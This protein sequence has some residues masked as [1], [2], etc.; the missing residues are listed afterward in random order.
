MSDE[1]IRVLVVDDH[2]VVRQGFTM[3]L[4]AF[5]EFQLVGEAKNGLHAVQLCDEL[6]PDV[7]LMDMVMPEM[8][9]IEATR[10]IREQHKD[11][12]VIALTSFTD[13]RELVEDAL[14]AGALGYLFK[15]VSIDELALAI[16]KVHQGDPVLAANATRMLIQATRDKSSHNFNLSDR[17]KEVLGL[18]VEGLNNPQIAERLT[19]SRSTVK[20]H[21]SSILSKLGVENRSEAVALAVQ[22]KL[23]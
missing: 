7:I 15:D 2:Q 4:T 12:Q 3:M 22:N 8:D 18:V 14:Q 17:E 13:R 11:T 1:K 20:F 10:R 23:V 9:G 16:H 19:I 6:Q 21:V 5:P